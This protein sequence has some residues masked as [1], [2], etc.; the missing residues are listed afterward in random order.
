MAIVIPTA[1]VVGW[2]QRR[3]EGADVAWLAM[4]VC[5]GRMRGRGRADVLALPLSYPR[6]NPKG[7]AT[8]KVTPLRAKDPLPCPSLKSFD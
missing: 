5:V 3:A 4:H 8:Y 1:S 6:S 7:R 2:D